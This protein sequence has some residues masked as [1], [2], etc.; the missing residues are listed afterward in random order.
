MSNTVLFV[1]L[2]ACFFQSGTVLDDRDVA[3]TYSFTA[4]LERTY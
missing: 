1:C 3:V 2:L 4:L